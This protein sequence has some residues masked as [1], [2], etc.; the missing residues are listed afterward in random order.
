MVI[1]RMYTFVNPVFIYV[2]SVDEWAL[3]LKPMTARYVA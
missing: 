1:E 3:V 2:F